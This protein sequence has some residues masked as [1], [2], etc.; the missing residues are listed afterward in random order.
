MPQSQ[1]YKL[2]YSTLIILVIKELQVDTKKCTPNC[3][4]A[5]INKPIKPKEVQKYEK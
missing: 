2:W 5:G 3:N 4:T 1:Q